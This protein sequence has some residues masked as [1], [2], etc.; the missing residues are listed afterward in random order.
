MCSLEINLTIKSPH[1]TKI[2]KVFISINEQCC[3]DIMII[4]LS[5]NSKSR[6]KLT[7]SRPVCQAW[8]KKW[9]F[10]FQKKKEIIQRNLLDK[11]AY[12]WFPLN[13]LQF[14]T[15]L[16]IYVCEDEI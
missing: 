7:I 4:S 1:P 13:H 16:Q 12:Y 10:C 5:V 3:H 6:I 2:K 11:Y 15:I 9:I 8:L 14:L